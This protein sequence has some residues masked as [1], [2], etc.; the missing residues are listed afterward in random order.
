M[1]KW[2]FNPFVFI[3][4]WQALGLGFLLMAFTCVIAFF[5]KTHFDGVIDAHFGSSFPIE[6]AVFE[7]INAWLISVIVFYSAGLILSK[8]KIRLIDVA[9]TM[10]LARAPMLAVAIIGFVPVLHRLPTANNLAGI[11]IW[12]LIL[13]LFSIWMIAL[14]YNTFTISCN[15]K[16]SKAISGFIVSIIL[17]EVISKLIFQQVYTHFLSK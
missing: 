14:M 15:L 16:G 9:G 11:A 12:S 5:S 13:L 8:S 17:A 2:F 4:G 3:A 7:Q 6:V 10:A 1:K